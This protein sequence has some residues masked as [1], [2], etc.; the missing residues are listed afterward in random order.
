MRRYTILALLLALCSLANAQFPERVLALTDKPCYVAGERMWVS[1]S[2][3]PADLSQ[4][5]YVELSDTRGMVAQTMVQLT[6]GR[7]WAKIALPQGMH[8]GNYQLSAYTRNLRTQGPHT[9]GRTLVG[10]INASQQ[11]DQDHITFLPVKTGDA[12]ALPLKKY[13]TGETAQI[14]LPR[15]SMLTIRTLSV[16]RNPLAIEAYASTCLQDA[17]PASVQ[18]NWVPELEGH[19]VMARPTAQGVVQS[20]LSIVGKGIDVYDGQPQP[21]GT[22]LYYTQGLH[23]Q[24]PLIVSG[25]DAQG[26][27]V[28]MQLVSPFAQVLPLSLPP[29]EVRCDQQTLQQRSIGAQQ[30]QVLT[31]WERVDTLEH[32][33][34]LLSRAPHMYYDMEEYTQFS[35]VHEALREFIHGISRRTIDGRPLLFVPQSESKL[36]SNLPALVLLDGMPVSD[37]DDILRYD[38]RLLKYVQIYTGGYTFGATNCHGVIAFITRRGLLSNYT[39]DEGTHLVRYQMPQHRPVFQTPQLPETS[40]VLWLPLVDSSSVSFAVPSSPGVYQVILQGTDAQGDLFQSVQEF[41]V[42]D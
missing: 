34:L 16:V 20:R 41:E 6:D 38:A 28:G 13:Q 35:T 19:I 10:V 26:R 31:S 11:S 15:D 22:W 32:T 4:V 27:P 37:V 14:T 39:L 3:E 30:E 8:S 21:D 9:F 29:L 33:V 18:D 12:L 2:V 23:G 36:M 1:V 25:Q 42:R 40:T 24:L 17:T 7:G 5:A